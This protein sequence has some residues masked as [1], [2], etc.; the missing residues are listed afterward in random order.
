MASDLQ[1]PTYVAELL[2]RQTALQAEAQSLIAALA[3]PEVLGQVG[4]IYQV[5][6]S[7]SGL[8]VWRDLD[9]VIVCERTVTLPHVTRALH[10]LLTSEQLLDLHYVNER[11]S[12]QPEGDPAY[13]RYYF[14]L[15]YTMTEAAIWKI[16]LSFYFSDTVLGVLEELRSLQREMSEEARLAILWIKDVWH[17]LP[18]YPYQVG[19]YEIY[20]AVL[21]AG[22]RTPDEFDAYLDEHGLPSSSTAHSNG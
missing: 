9:Y 19:G 18:M 10:P 17:H 2:S 15:R 20:Q 8:M 4:T 21:T 11:G 1:D 12:H 7:V 14:V 5:G 3:L 22:V 13:D 16:D 6:S